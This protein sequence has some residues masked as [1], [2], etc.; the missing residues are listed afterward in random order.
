MEPLPAD[1]ETKERCISTV[2]ASKLSG[3]NINLQPRIRRQI[4]HYHTQ[5]FTNV[6]SENKFFLRYGQSFTRDKSTWDTTL[7]PSKS[8]SKLR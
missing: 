8:A 2:L 5:Q 1:S 7:M 6:Q 3:I 4:G